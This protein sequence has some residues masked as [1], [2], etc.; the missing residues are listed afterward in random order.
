MQS[1]DEDGWTDPRDDDAETVQEAKDC[2]LG[3]GSSG[4]WEKFTPQFGG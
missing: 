2:L 1:Y 4:V 3:E